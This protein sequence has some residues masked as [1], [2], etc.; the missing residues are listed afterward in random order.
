MHVFKVI[1]GMLEE[2]MG[3][4]KTSGDLSVEPMARR[5][6]SGYG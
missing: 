3:I 4:L 2:L 6:R 1:E 5:V